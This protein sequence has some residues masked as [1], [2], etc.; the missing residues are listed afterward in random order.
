MKTI[1]LWSAIA[2]LALS[3]ASF[4]RDCSK[5]DAAN[6]EKALDRVVNWQGMHKAWQDYGHCD[7]G[8]VGDAFTEA[9]LRLTVEWKNVD[10][11]AKA[12]DDPKYREFV[13]AHLRSPEAKSDYDAV[14]SRTKANCPRGL[15]GFCAD[16]RDAIKPA[17]AAQ[18]EK[19]LDLQ[20]LKPLK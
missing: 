18:P 20:P 19:P 9:L 1:S 8:P 4:A 5:A 11:L 7:T 15:D 12:M 10:A 13:V 2:L 16:L 3:G 17:A 14:Y 6:A